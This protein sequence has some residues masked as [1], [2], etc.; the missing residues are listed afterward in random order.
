MS[1][2]VVI[3][4]RAASKMDEYVDTHCEKIGDNYYARTQDCSANKIGLCQAQ[5]DLSAIGFVQLELVRSLYG[6][7]IRYRSGL[8]NFALFS[9]SVDRIKRAIGD[10]SIER[11][12]EIAQAWVQARPDLRSVVLRSFEYEK[13]LKEGLRL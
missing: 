7:S 10:A 13:A 11:K 1:D 9:P 5:R 8:Q 12:L 6:W 4:Q 3:G 2:I